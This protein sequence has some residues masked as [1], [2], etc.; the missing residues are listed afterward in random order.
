MHGLIWNK[1]SKIKTEEIIYYTLVQ[2][3]MT[4]AAE[5]WVIYKRNQGK[6]LTVEMKYW[7]RCCGLTRRDEVTNE[8]IR[9]MMEEDKNAL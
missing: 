2:S 6:I 9:R 8:W 7:R 1:K 5:D 3:I 4:Y